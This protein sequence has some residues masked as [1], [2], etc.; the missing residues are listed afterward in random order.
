MS[1][2]K[3]IVISSPGDVIN[4]LKM[5]GDF[6]CTN[7]TLPKTASLPDNVNKKN[8]KGGIYRDKAVRFPKPLG[9][10]VSVDSC[11]L[12]GIVINQSFVSHDDV[13]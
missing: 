11:S 10:A 12:L 2:E 7:K 6:Y 8:K 5:G 13:T 3:K 1:H 4:G 9:G